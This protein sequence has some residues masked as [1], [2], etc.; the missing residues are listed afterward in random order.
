M[1]R[2][3]KDKGKKGREREVRGKRKRVIG[4]EENK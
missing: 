4:E 3:K 1:G 2:E